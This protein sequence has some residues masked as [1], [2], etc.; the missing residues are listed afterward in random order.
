MK[1]TLSTEKW[2]EAHVCSPQQGDVRNSEG[3]TVIL[4]KNIKE[5]EGI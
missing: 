5:A 2:R 3:S 1:N 4:Q